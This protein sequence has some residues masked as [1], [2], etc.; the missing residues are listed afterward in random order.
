MEH[1]AHIAQAVFSPD[2][3]HLATA[4]WDGTTRVWDAA[5]GAPI[6]LPLQHA[7]GVNALA[8]RGDGARLA[9]ASM[10]ARNGRVFRYEVEVPGEWEHAP[11]AARI[12]DVA[13]SQPLTAPMAHVGNV[14]SV[15]FSSDGTRLLT[16]CEAVAQVWDAATGE[17][18]GAPLVHIEAILSA[19]FD[20]AGDRIVT[21]SEDG[22]GRLWRVSTGRPIAATLS[23][24]SQAVY[25]ARFSPDGRFVATG[26]GDGTAR[27]WDAYTGRPLGEPMRHNFAFEDVRSVCFSSDGG[28]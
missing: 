28:Y 25:C 23:H 7:W 5:S 8:F 6:G 14:W 20:N 13:T 1:E 4:S 22:T 15:A 2:G 19:C 16:T 3:Q 17:R 27:I 18:I 11:G 21:T 24:R 26:G 10:D 9:T 12:W